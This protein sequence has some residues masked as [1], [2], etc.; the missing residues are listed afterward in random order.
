MLY[1]HVM[2]TEQQLIQGTLSLNTKGTGFVRVEGYEEAIE[3]APEDLGTALHRDIVLIQ[4]YPGVNQ[5]GKKT[6]EVVKIIKEYKRT[7]TGVVQEKNNIWFIVPDDNKM[8]FDIIIP[9]TNPITVSKGDKVFARITAW[10]NRQAPIIGQIEEVLGRHGAHEAEMRA[11]ALDQGFQSSFPHAVQDAANEIKKRGIPTDEYARRRDMRDTTTFTIDPADAKDFDDALSVK[12]LDNG[13]YEIGIHIADVSYFMHEED[14]LDK[15]AYERATSVYLVDRT[16]PML[17]NVLSDDLCSLTEKEDKVTYSVVVTMND[18]AQVLDRW[19]GRTIIHSDKRF[20]YEDAQNILDTGQGEFVKELQTLNAIAK[21]LFGERKTRHA[22]SL[23]QEE[24]KFILNEEKEPVSV[25]TKPRLETNQL[26]EEFMLLAN[27]EVAKF[28]S[29]DQ[30]TKEERLGLYRVHAPPAQDRVEE[31]LGYLELFGYHLKTEADGTLSA[32]TLTEFLD[33]L[34]GKPEKNMLS[35]HV[36]R[37]MQKAY[38]TTKNIG[39]FGLGYEFYTHFTSPIRRYPDVIVHR[40]LT[41]YLEGKSVTRDLW[42]A[43]EEMALHCSEQ[44]KMAQT[45][46]R[47][48]IKYKQVEYMAKRVGQTFSGLITGVTKWGMYVEETETKCEGMASLRSEDSLIF[49]FDPD[50]YAVTH[51]K[52]GKVFR[53]GDTV[54]IKV[55]KTNLDRK[56]IDYEVVVQ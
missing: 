51:T 44:E 47:G 9:P 34:D 32:K 41:T 45:A 28:L 10:P 33:S 24:V 8:P 20:A 26:I 37:T 39:H 2:T 36:V 30:T 27:V 29:K 52:T 54:T 11:I 15:E 17:P 7:F 5:Y 3:I 56:Q 53:L 31:L 12:Y 16:I 23:E 25:Y 50:T 13:T 21:K 38:Y 40:L 6:G 18:E 4:I 1:L 22:L 43:Y 42:G 19:F 49:T 48:S 35:T 46:E 55:L 14:T